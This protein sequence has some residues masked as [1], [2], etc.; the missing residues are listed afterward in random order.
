MKYTFGSY[1][2][3]IRMQ[4]GDTLRTFCLKNKFNS[5]II[6]K[7]ER[8]VEIPLSIFEA[9]T[10]ADALKL[11]QSTKERRYFIDLYLSAVA[12]EKPKK[13]QTEE[14]ILKKL[15]LFICGKKKPTKKELMKIYKFL[16]KHN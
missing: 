11:G 7:Y 14:D 10:L 1:L 8:D 5:S 3:A 15:P 13:E 12:D 16:E 9:R 6:S 2:Q 4:N